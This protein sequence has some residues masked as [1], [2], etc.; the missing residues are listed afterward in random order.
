MDSS[1]M[2]GVL[3]I[4]DPPPPDRPGEEPKG[5]PRVVEYKKVSQCNAGTINIRPDFR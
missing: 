1:T 2:R 4:Q 5:R 3:I